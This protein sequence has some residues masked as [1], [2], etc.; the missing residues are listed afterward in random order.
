MVESMQQE[1]EHMR[2]ERARERETAKNVQTFLREQLRNI[3]T[4]SVQT[5]PRP[6][7]SQPD[8]ATSRPILYPESSG[9]INDDVIKG[10]VG[11]P[12]TNLDE[13]LAAQLRATLDVAPKPGA[14]PTRVKTESAPQ[15]PARKRPD[16]RSERKAAAE[17]ET[18]RGAQPDAAKR[19][20]PANAKSAERK[21]R[22]ASSQNNKSKRTPTYRGSSDNSDSDSSSG[23]SDQDSDH[24]D[25]SS[26]E[27]VVPNV[28]TVTKPGGTMFTFRPYVNASALEDFDEKASLAVRTRWLERFQSIPLQGGWTDKVKI[29][30]MKLK[31]SAAVRNWRANLRPKVRRD[32]KKLLKE[33]REMYCKAKTSDS[34]RYY[35]MTQRKSESPLE[36]YY[37]LNKVA[38]KAGIDFASSS[39]QRE[40]HLKV[41]TMKLLDSRLRTILRGQRIRKLRDLEYVLKQHEEM[42][43]GDD[44]DGPPHKRDFRADNVPHGR[45]QPKRSGRAYVIQDEDSPDEVEDDRDCPAWK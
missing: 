40:R 14:A 13:L 35:T 8:L 39:K 38:D 36:F 32:W 23:S 5:T 15:A 1:L 21:G 45:F 34:E 16:V 30:E 29:Y 10:E 43:Q 11:R 26:F 37:R 42:T 27:D 18:R 2:V 9:V 4:T 41:F 20:R 24:S 31:L 44:Y 28:P 6:V 3:R 25:S 7:T 22:D 33:F 19:A 12:S 17:G